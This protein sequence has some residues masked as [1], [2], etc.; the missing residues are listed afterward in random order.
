MAD[1]IM[2]NGI[3]YSAPNVTVILYGNAQSGVTSINYKATQAKENN[4]GLGKEPVSRGYGTKTYEANIEMYRDAWQAI[5]DASPSK[6][7]TK[8]PPTQFQVIFSGDGVNYKQDNLEFA[9]WTEDSLAVASGDTSIKVSIPLM[10]GGI[11]HV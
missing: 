10:I 2:I 4:Y 6:D 3:A 9:E 5:I 11:T 8:I 1:T 7:P